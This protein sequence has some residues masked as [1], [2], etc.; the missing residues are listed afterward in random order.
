[1]KKTFLILGVAVLTLAAGCTP[2][3]NGLTS[4]EK[5]AGW[6]LLFDGQ[7]L[8]GWTASENQG[9]FTVQ[10][11]CLVVNGKRS[12][13]FYVGPVQGHDFKNF[14]L[15]LEIMTFPKANSG[16]YIHTAW[17]ETGWPDKGYEIQVNN[18]HT[19]PKRTAGLY[20]IKDNLEAVAKDN[21]WFTM[22]IKVEGKR[23][24]TSVNDRVVTDYTEEEKPPRTPN[25]AER[26]VTHGT[27]AIQGHDPGSKVMY[28][29]IKARVLP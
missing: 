26:L 12:H 23:I 13:L 16:V 11:G 21:E 15:Q 2:G 28:R 18:S 14:E 19:D 29:N 25:H 10:D 17:Q 6:T 4:Q 24:I 9:S 7:S 27:F 22:R 20:D 5:S 8:D 1:M 3:I